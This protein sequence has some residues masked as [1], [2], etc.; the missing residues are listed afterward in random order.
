MLNALFGE[1]WAGGPRLDSLQRH[2]VMNQNWVCPGR[3]PVQFGTHVLAFRRYFFLT[4]LLRPEDG[5]LFLRI[6]TM[7]VGLTN[8][9]VSRSRIP[10]SSSCSRSDLIYRD[11]KNF[12]LRECQG[13]SWPAELPAAAQGGLQCRR[14]IQ[15]AYCQPVG[16]DSTQQPSGL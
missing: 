9:V 12:G 3:H 7:Y 2:M 6:V 14:E 8:Y 4:I 15:R 13:T 16:S 5:R 1:T 10:Q 11:D